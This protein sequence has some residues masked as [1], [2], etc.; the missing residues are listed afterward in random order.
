MY[1]IWL[2]IYIAYPHTIYFS[3]S[4]SF[5]PLLGFLI[6]SASLLKINV[7]RFYLS[8]LDIFSIYEIQYCKKNNLQCC[9]SENCTLNGS[10]RWTFQFVWVYLIHQSQLPAETYMIMAACLVPDTGKLGMLN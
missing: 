10:S 6:I 1:I 9:T 3:R 2:H 7:L 8:E 4:E 5:L